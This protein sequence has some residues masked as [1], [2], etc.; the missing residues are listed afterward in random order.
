MLERARAPNVHGRLRTAVVTAPA[1]AG[2][3]VAV[4]L[5]LVSSGRGR[6]TVYPPVFEFDP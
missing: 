2:T 1:P 4:A 5:S 3:L 6:V